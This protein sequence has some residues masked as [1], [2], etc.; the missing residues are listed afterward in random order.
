[1]PLSNLTL[2]QT[3]VNLRDFSISTTGCLWLEQAFVFLGVQY[4]YA[5]RCFQ[6]NCNFNRLQCCR[7][8]N[9]KI[10][11]TIDHL[12]TDYWTKHYS[13]GESVCVFIGGEREKK[14]SAFHFSSSFFPFIRYGLFVFRICFSQALW[15]P[16]SKRLSWLCFWPYNKGTL[17]CFI[18][19]SEYHGAMSQTPLLP[20]TKE[21]L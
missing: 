19:A 5:C 17:F 6:H 3:A 9:L 18:S 2:R 14:V 1:M 8:E 20:S 16:L 15:P 7:V 4:C 10:S 12:N 21:A 11:S 13:S